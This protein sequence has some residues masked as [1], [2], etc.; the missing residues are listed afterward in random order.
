[1]NKFEIKYQG[2]LR[3]IAT[4][5]DSGSEI[6]TDAPKDN[7]GLGQTFSPTDMVCSA[8]ASCILTIMAIAVEKKNVDIKGTTAMVKKTMGNNPRRIAK[9]EIDIVF[10]KGYDSKTKTILERAAYNC[11]VHHTLSETV[12]KNISFTYIS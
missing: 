9:I 11:P 12:E 2:N 7:H 10:P 3:T 6:S 8:L 4:H 5:L 1:V